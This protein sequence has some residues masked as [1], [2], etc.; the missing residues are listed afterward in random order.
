MYEVVK[1]DRWYPVGQVPP[2]PVAFTTHEVDGQ[3]EYLHNG[4]HGRKYTW[5][6]NQG[7]D[8]FIVEHIQLDTDTCCG[9]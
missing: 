3:V 7:S 1:V 6:N 8:G 2:P 4:R 5:F 9:D